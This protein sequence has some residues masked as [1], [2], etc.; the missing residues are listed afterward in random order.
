AVLIG[1]L[2]PAVQKVR[3]AAARLE[4]GGPAHSKL[5]A[6]LRAFADGSV[7]IQRDAAK[8]ASDAALSGEEGRLAPA[9]LRT[10]FG[11]L[12]SS[13]KAAAALSREIAALLPAVQT[14][15]RREEGQ[16]EREARGHQHQA[17]VDAQMAVTE[18]ADAL[19]QLDASMAKVFPQCHNYFASNG[20]GVVRF[21]AHLAGGP[22]PALCFSFCR[23]CTC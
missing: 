19:R 21:A 23:R 7:N 10:P 16:E 14:P 11:D 20:V 17:L 8:L 1:L 13:E 9:E 22:A 18:A 15:G 5:A 6:D 4:R 2:L 12:V 3:E